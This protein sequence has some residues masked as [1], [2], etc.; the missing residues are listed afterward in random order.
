MNLRRAS[1]YTFGAAALGF[2][3]G[4]AV[5]TA[6]TF[7]VKPS[8]Y[9]AHAIICTLASLTCATISGVDLAATAPSPQ[10]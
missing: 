2:A 9:I 6:A 5:N 10:P 1:G 4:A 7:Y 3:F 8:N